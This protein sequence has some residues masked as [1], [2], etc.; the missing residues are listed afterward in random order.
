MPSDEICMYSRAS[1]RFDLVGVIFEKCKQTQVHFI[2]H[3]H[4]T[5]ER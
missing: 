1:M 2:A 4:F 3:S 5:W